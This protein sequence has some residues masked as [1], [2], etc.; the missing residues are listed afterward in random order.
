LARKLAEEKQAAVNAVKQ[1]AEH[2]MDE[3]EL[4]AI[5]Q[6]VE[7]ATA[8]AA[9]EA[10]RADALARAARQMGPSGSSQPFDLERLRVRL[11]RLL[12]LT[13]GPQYN[14]AADVCGELDLQSLH[15]AY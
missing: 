7:Q 6:S 2:S 13:R 10:A 3:E 8:E 4:E 12:C 14:A 15:Y 9:R 11:R 5:K 1:G